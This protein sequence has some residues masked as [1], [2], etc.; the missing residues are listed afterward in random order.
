MNKIKW[1]GSEELSR[2]LRS[3]AEDKDIVFVGTHDTAPYVTLQFI[4]DVY[5]REYHS[6][7]ISGDGEPSIW[8]SELVDSDREGEIVAS[9]EDYLVSGCDTEEYPQED[10]V[11]LGKLDESGRYGICINYDNTNS[12]AFVCVYGDS[13]CPDEDEWIAEG[14]SM[15]GIY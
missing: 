6:V 2:T 4:R 12:I 9:Y 8:V 13:P 11:D 7:D 14:G 15:E 5:M 3:Y 10:L 1:I